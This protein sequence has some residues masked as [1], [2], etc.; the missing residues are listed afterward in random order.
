MAPAALQ[1]DG[2]RIGAADV[3]RAA[4]EFRL[5]L[6]I[7]PVRLHSGTWRFQLDR[8]AI[9]IET[10][11]PGLRA[12]HLLR[13][14]DLDDAVDFHGLDVRTTPVIGSSSVEVE[15]SPSDARTPAPSPT[16]SPAGVPSAVRDIAAGADAVHAI[17]HV[18]IRSTD[19]ERAIALWR[20]RLGIRLALDRE[21]PERG[22]RMLFFR[23]AGMTLE[24]VSAIGAGDPA[25]RDALDGV[26]YQVRNLAGCRERL[27]TA[28]L[29]VSPVRDGHKRGTRVATVRSGTLGIPTLLIEHPDRA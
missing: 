19:L 7:E 1:F 16:T 15:A 4:E 3:E 18:V 5:L 2:V 8:G 6:G 29:D 13:S 14:S 17:D 26:A 23:S 28:G 20:D 12:L 11:P 22:L 10:G 27:A 24:F 25:G 21:F 9:E